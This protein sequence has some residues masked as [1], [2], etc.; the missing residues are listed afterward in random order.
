VR[1]DESGGAEVELLAREEQRKRRSAVTAA[2]GLTRYAHHGNSPLRESGASNKTTRRCSHDE[3]LRHLNNV[4]EED[5]LAFNI[6]SRIYTAV[7]STRSRWRGRKR[8]LAHGGSSGI[9]GR[10]DYCIES[11]ERDDEGW[12]IVTAGPHRHRGQ[13]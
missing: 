3:E 9:H 6:E 8:F 13:R 12:E 5:L 11:K 7:D 1:V 10:W 2:V 4:P